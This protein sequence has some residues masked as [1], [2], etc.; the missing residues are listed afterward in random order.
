MFWALRY[1][2]GSKVRAAVF[3]PSHASWSSHTWGSIYATEISPSSRP[4]SRLGQV[5]TSARVSIIDTS[6]TITHDCRQEQEVEL[7]NWTHNMGLSSGSRDT[8]L[9]NKSDSGGPLNSPGSGM[10]TSR[11]VRAPCTAFDSPETLTTGSPLLTEALLITHSINTH[12]GCYVY[13]MLYFYSKVSWRKC[14][15][16]ILRK[17]KPVYSSTVL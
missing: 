12:L 3:L 7:A 11:T 9:R 16:E 6:S 1:V 13:C 17:R 8:N 15:G 10:P 2:A 4:P 14:Y 5:L